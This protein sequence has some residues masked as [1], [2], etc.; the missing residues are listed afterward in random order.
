MKLNSDE[1]ELVVDSTLINEKDGGID[2]NND[3]GIQNSAII[4][5]SVTSDLTMETSDLTMEK[6]TN[7][8]E[9]IAKRNSTNKTKDG[10]NPTPKKR[11]SQRK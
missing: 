7:T 9:K 8:V 4:V 11:V 10:S 5:G 6:E 2:N 3:A 1:E